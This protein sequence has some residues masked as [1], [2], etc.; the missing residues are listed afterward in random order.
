P[1][2]SI[3]IV[4]NGAGAAALSVTQLLLKAG[5]KDITI[6]D[7][8]GTI[9]QGRQAGMNPYK[10]RIAAITNLDCNQGSLAEVMKGADVFIGLSVPGTVNQAMVKSMAANSVI[11]ALSNPVPEIMPDEAY[12]AGAKVVATG[13]SDFPNQVNN[14]LAFPGIFR[15]AL[16]V[17]ARHINDDMK[18]AAGQAI[19]DLISDKQLKEGT[20]IPGAFDFR[21]PPAVAQAV[22]RAAMDTGESRIS[23]K[24]A[25]V[26]SELKNYLYEGELKKVTE[27]V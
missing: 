6:C 2:A 20:I 21:V 25:D 4:I 13:R 9:Y 11:M 19:A 24:P 22:A 8:K 17:R 26:H 14:S 1:L 16:D 10:E 3:R 12:A 18:L 15:G 23:V 7:S 5:A 27:V